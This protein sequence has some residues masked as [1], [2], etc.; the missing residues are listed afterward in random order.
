MA[1]RQFW[2]QSASRNL[3]QNAASSAPD[4]P[5]TASVEPEGDHALPPGQTRRGKGVL[6]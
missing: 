2:L 3:G 5:R 6:L 1:I 4:S